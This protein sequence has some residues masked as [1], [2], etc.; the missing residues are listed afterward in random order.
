MGQV[1]PIRAVGSPRITAFPPGPSASQV[2]N[3][4]ADRQQ[5]ERD[6]ELLRFLGE[7]IDALEFAIRQIGGLSTRAAQAAGII[8]PGVPSIP[9]GQQFP[10]T[11][12]IAPG[13][14]I[15]LG[16]VLHV[17]NGLAYLA[18]AK[19]ENRYVTDWASKVFGSTVTLGDRD[20]SLRVADAGV[21]PKLYL[22]ETP[23]WVTT[24]PL[25]PTDNRI[26]QRVGYRS[27][28]ATSGL[29]PVAFEPADD[30]GNWI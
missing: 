2:C 21:G 9:T 5:E 15:L 6:S 16:H 30:N 1:I 22:S 8:I 3:E 23:G 29:S 20:A 12:I 14:A 28:Q 24:T 18:D 11:A 4:L 19:D 26:W 13:E 7:H 10:R 17:E 27:R 25:F